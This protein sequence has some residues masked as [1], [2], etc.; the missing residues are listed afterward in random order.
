MHI[1]RNDNHGFALIV[2]TPLVFHMS[3]SRRLEYR[4]SSEISLV[5]G[6]M[7]FV[8][9]LFSFQHLTFFPDMR[10]MIGTQ[11]L[12]QLFIMTVLGL[13][14][15]VVVI[16]SSILI[17]E[18]PQHIRKFGVLIWIFS[19]ISFFGSGGF[20]IGGILGVI[21]GFLAVTKG[22]SFFGPK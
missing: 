6:C 1:I 17:Y 12:G 20:I 10:W 14:S 11:L 15:G 2:P 9:S 16:V 19:G 5:A 8:A 4:F 3:A 22:I 13:A 21:G 7:I 18:Q